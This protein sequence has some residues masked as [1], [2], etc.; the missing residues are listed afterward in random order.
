MP[1]ILNAGTCPTEELA[2]YSFSLEF[3]STSGDNLAEGTPLRIRA[4]L[5]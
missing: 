4:A 1:K 2:T 3:S 5:R